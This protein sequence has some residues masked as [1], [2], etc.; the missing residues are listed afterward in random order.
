MMRCEVQERGQ[1]LRHLAGQ[2]L[3]RY[4]FSLPYFRGK[5]RTVQ[6]IGSCCGWYAS[7][8]H[9]VER[10]RLRWELD[11]RCII[12]RSLY[13]L[14]TFEYEFWETEFLEAVIKPGWCVVDVGANIGYY[15]L[16]AA[17]QVGP[18][19]AVYGFEPSGPVFE[20]LQRNIELNSM[21]WAHPVKV[22]LGDTE[23]TATIPV[24]ERWNQHLQGVNVQWKGHTEHIPM[25]TLDNFLRNAGCSRVH[26]IKA[27]IEGYEPHLLDGASHTLEEWRPIL[28]LELNPLTL[29]RY[30]FDPHD[31]LSRVE[32]HGYRIFRLR[33]RKL[34]QLVAVPR[35]GHHINIIAVPKESSLA[36]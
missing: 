21:T 22:A 24:P 14:G 7:G 6:W 4:E 15:T 10:R 16:L 13:Y 8:V 36:V 9:T 31:L 23:G 3:A 25:T 18:S 17:Q 33:R 32:L 2:A 29:A 20:Q 30:G 27:D 12:Q 5:W 26:L 1:S 34:E 19:G 35:L 28:M 11:K